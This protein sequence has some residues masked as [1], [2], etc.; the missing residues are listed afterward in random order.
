MADIASQ[1]PTTPEFNTV[2]FTV[3]TPTIATETFSGKTRRV[4]FGH[5][6]YSWQAQYST[7]TD[8]QAGI[9]E[10][11]LAQTY[12]SLLSFEIILPKVSYS[13]SQNPPSTVPATT[14][15]Y[16]IGAKAVVVDNCGANKDVLYVGDYFKFAGHSK[17][18]QAVATA[19]SNGS[20]QA[21]IYF[22]GS[23][24]ANVGNNENVIVTAV[25]FTAIMSNPTQK[26]DVG[27]GGLTN[28]SV[29]MRETW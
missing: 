3:N 17:V 18:Y 2:G 5:Q 13:K 26:F 24:V 11:Y 10:G 28:I 8:Q 22:A 19:T 6:F 4:G 21:T 7:L 14:S 25:P 16:T 12:G 9:V 29:D 20:G 23:L 15:T 1:Y 27:V